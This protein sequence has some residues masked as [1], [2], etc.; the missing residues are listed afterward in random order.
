M[1]APL[2]PRWLS[3]VDNVVGCALA[4]RA[5]TL[6]S[7]EDPADVEGEA[8]IRD[9]VFRSAE[10]AMAASEAFPNVECPC[11]RCEEMAIILS[12]SVQMA[13]VTGQTEREVFDEAL[14]TFDAYMKG[15]S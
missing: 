2:S 5:K 10:L 1:S 12:A 9:L 14:K 11:G 8:F 4:F 15:R 6:F 3:A 7:G 13:V